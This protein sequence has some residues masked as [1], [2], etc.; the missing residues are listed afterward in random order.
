MGIFSSLRERR[1]AKAADAP[2]F[3]D[4]A[5]R[6]AFEGRPGLSRLGE[7]DRGRLKR[8]AAAFAAEKCIMVPGGAAAPN[9]IVAAVSALASLP[10]LELSSSPGSL[11][12]LD[13][14]RGWA[15]ILVVP[16]SY[17]VTRS[18]YDEAGTLHEYEDELAGED[19]ALGPVVL[20]A[21]DIEEAG[22]G[23]GYDV[24]IHEMAH[25][26]DGL[27]GVYDGC[28]P[29]PRGL[30]Y[31]AW[32]SDF[33]EAFA[34]L[35]GGGG[36]KRGRARDPFDEYAAADPAEFFACSCELFFDR[37]VALKAAYPAVYGRLAEFFR[38]EPAG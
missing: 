10:I 4:G 7:G 27:D 5:W 31:A 23:D 19:S 37:P 9:T 26:L 18:F 32:R 29:L 24:V 3:D 2:A 11:D 20:A 21:P 17:R 12:G 15:T 14:Y 36:R 1:R 35:R 34:R 16:G 30:S 38:R 8:L 25:K 22:R 13:W 28:P 6:S 33:S